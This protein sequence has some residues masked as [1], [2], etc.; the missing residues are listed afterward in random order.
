MRYFEVTAIS[1]PPKKSKKAL[2]FTLYI[3]TQYDIIRTPE[4]KKMP[5]V[6]RLQAGQTKVLE[7]LSLS[8]CFT[9]T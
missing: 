8:G 1:L 6:E 7:A 5:A 3:S 4:H 9:L 2:I